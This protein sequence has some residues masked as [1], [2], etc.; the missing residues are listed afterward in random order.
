M[1]NQ[2]VYFFETSFSNPVVSRLL[3]QRRATLLAAPDTCCK[4]FEMVRGRRNALQ[5]GTSLTKIYFPL[6]F[7]TP[8]A[9]KWCSYRMM[10]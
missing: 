7:F 5:L 2:G 8:S 4:S 10:S 6:R 9:A 3:E 1:G